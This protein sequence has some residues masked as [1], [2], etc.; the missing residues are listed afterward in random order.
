MIHLYN[1]L[2]SEKTIRLSYMNYVTRIEVF[3]V[4]ANDWL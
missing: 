3:V 4:K 2:E 1:N